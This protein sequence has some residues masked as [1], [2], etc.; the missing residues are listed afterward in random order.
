MG[1]RASFSPYNYDDMAQAQHCVVVEAL[2]IRHLRRVLGLFM[3]GMHA[4]MRGIFPSEFMD[5]L[6]PLPSLDGPLSVG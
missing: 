5:A 6:M 2:G 3:G 1:L 4:W